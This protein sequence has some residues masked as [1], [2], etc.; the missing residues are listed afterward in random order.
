MI[1]IKKAH[2]GGATAEDYS[3]VRPSLTFASG[4]TAKTI[5]VTATDDDEDDD[6]ESIVLGFESPLP[7]GVMVG[8][9][10]STTVALADNDTPPLPH[11]SIA[12]ASAL[13]GSGSVVF[14]LRLDT[15]SKQPVTVSW[16]TADGTAMSAAD[17][18]AMTASMT[19]GT[20]SFAPGQTQQT[21]RVEIL[22]DRL[23]ESDET[24][25]VRLSDPTNGRIA[26]RGGTATG[27]IVDD[28]ATPGLTITDARA[29]ES[30]GEIAFLVTLEAA[31]GRPVSV[32]CRSADGTA[33]VDEDYLGENGVLVFEPGETQKAIRLTVLDDVVDEPDETVMLDLSKPTNARLAEEVVTATGT[34]ADDDTGVTRAWLVRFGRAVTHH[35]LDSVVGRMDGAFGTGLQVTIAGHRLP[36]AAPAVERED[37]AALAAATYRTVSFR[38]LLAG[39]GF[40]VALTPQAAPELTTAP[41]TPADA[42]VRWTAWGRGAAM[43]FEGREGGLSMQGDVL[44][45]SFGMD[46]E[47][48]GVL[49]GLA[50]ARSG[51][52]GGYAERRGVDRP[53]RDGDL[54]AVLT[55]VHPYVRVSVHDRLQVWGLFGY[56][57]GTLEQREAGDEEKTGISM[58]LGAAGG[59]AALL[60]GE[61]SGGVRLALKAD[62]YLSR[63]TSEATAELS[64]MEA[65]VRRLRLLTEGSAAMDL[66]ASRVLIPS[67]EVG[68]RVDGGDAETGAGLEA[69]VALRWADPAWGADA[70]GQRTGAADA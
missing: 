50:V 25:L 55:S 59:R 34:I 4:E 56:G 21:I 44:T 47:H 24:F 16:T 33:K 68:V 31:S 45:G 65:D 3:G 5:V 63:M 62:G 69:G 58:L 27:T 54:R 36:G 6:G 2:D 11:V 60:T 43:H 32:A 7:A 42:G 61:R 18:A 12:D 30:S 23:D 48:H 13:E 26:S 20:V 8:T 1:A 53:A 22:D 17:Y 46:L 52:D 10:A 39:S 49:A 66:G 35:V 40:Q 41:T 64:V 38:E 37:R 70:C 19:G 57:L 9:T 51:G 14:A 15:A 67:L 28:D 29:V